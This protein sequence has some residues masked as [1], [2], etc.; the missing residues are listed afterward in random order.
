MTEDEFRANPPRPGDKVWL[1]PMMIDIV[2]PTGFVGVGNFLFPPSVVDRIERAPRVPVVGDRV[3]TTGHGRSGVVEAIG[4]DGS[5]W[6]ALDG[7]P[8][9]IAKRQPLAHLQVIEP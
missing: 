1:K 5:A 7:N 9:N 3:R 2:T 8:R 6:V 4:R